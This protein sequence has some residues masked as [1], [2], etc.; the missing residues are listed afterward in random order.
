MST[1]IEVKYNA[2]KKTIGYE[3]DKIKQGKRRISTESLTFMLS[4]SIGLLGI[5]PDLGYPYK[6]IGNISFG[7][8][9]CF[10][11]PIVIKRVLLEEEDPNATMALIIETIFAPLG[12]CFMMFGVGAVCLGVELITGIIVCGFG[13]ITFFI[14]I[15]VLLYYM[16][17]PNKVAQKKTPDQINST[18]SISPPET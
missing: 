10:L 2:A 3:L 9:A 8:S 6:G 7:F 15:L 14:Y 16:F 17:F 18:N 13:A 4:I 12:I 11:S 5:L 1:D